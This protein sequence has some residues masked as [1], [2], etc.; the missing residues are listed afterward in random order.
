MNKVHS[1]EETPRPFTMAPCVVVER[2]EGK[3]RCSR[4]AVSEHA[5]IQDREWSRWLFTKKQEVNEKTTKLCNSPHRITTVRRPDNIPLICT[6][7]G[8]IHPVHS[9]P[10]SLATEAMPQT[11]LNFCHFPADTV[12][13]K[14]CQTLVQWWQFLL[15]IYSLVKSIE[16][17]CFCFQ[18]GLCSA[19]VVWHHISPYLRKPEQMSCRHWQNM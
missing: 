11:R 12:L 7:A 4:A 17:W 3:Q 6:G 2:L 5:G 14:K 9:Q 15:P 16:K 1:S 13:E 19:C 18:F 8:Q 10:M